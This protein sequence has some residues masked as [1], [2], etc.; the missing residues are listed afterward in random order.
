MKAMYPPSVHRRPHAPRAQNPVG[1][2][3]LATAVGLI[4]A[5][6]GGTVWAIRRRRSE[7][8]EVSLPPGTLLVRADEKNARGVPVKEGHVPIGTTI[9]LE[10]PIPRRMHSR[11]VE[12]LD[13]EIW[14]GWTIWEGDRSDFQAAPRQFKDERS[15]RVFIPVIAHAPLAA[16]ID[17]AIHEQDGRQVDLAE[18]KLAFQ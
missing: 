10:V 4:A 18:F 5:G 13:S 3:G 7:S 12:E 15:D 2:L 6:I 9:F 17:V 8:D 1:F 14:V 16:D 11:T